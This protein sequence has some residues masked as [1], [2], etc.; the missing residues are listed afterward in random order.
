[1]AH[2]TED[3]EVESRFSRVGGTVYQ[4]RSGAMA[5]WSDLA[6]AWSPIEVEI[7]DSADVGSDRTVLLFKLHG[8]GRVSGLRL[9]ESVAHRWHWIGERLRQVEY[10]DREEAELIVRATA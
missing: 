4:G 3:L 6:E 1:M 9:D 7:E 8:K 10:M 5:W 2:C